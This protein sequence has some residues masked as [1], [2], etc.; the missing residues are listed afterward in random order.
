MKWCS[1][2]ETYHH[3]DEEEGMNSFFQWIADFFRGMKPWVMVMPWEKAIRIRFGKHVR[4]FGAGMHFRFPHLDEYL[5]VNTRLRV[6]TTGTQTISTKDGK[7]VSASVSIGFLM[8]NPLESFRKV[9]FP[10]PTVAAYAGTLLS[11]YISERVLADISIPDLTNTLLGELGTFG[12]VHFEF[13]AVT[14][15]VVAKTF[16]LLQETGARGVFG[17]DGPT[18]HGIRTF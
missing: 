10:E 16:R 9:A 5:I 12:G 13:V 1:E 14:D 7:T 2:C 15:F 17:A 3:E 4:E 18:G 8:E 11:K 6:T